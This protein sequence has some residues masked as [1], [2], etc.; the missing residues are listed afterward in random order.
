L[1]DHLTVGFIA[2]GWSVKRLIR[3]I[4][5]SR[6]YQLCS[7]ASAELVTA[8]PDNLWIGRHLRRRL[9]AESL[10]D[11]MLVATGE[12]NVQPGRGSV[13]QHRDVLINELPPLHQPSSHRSVYL[14]MLRNSMP[15]DLT[16]FN[17][18]DAIAV[19]GKR[20]PSTLATQALYLLNNPFI[21]EQSRR[22][23][24][25]LKAAAVEQSERIR[26][27]YRH[28]FSRAPSADELQQAED[29]IR[30]TDLALAS[31]Q[32]DGAKDQSD[33]WAAFCQTLLVSNELRYVD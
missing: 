33:T 7:E 3:R 16:A 13:I 1:L 18:P 22:F 14:L 8:D 29:F 24:E 21:V 28:A 31:S 11:A 27:A 6:T 2:D 17:L 15:P 9:D 20:D 26:L 30:E 12:L 5:Q 4:V 19:T 23:A 25:R 32:S 10:R